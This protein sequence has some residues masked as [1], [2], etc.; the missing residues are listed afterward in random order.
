MKCYKREWF[1]KRHNLKRTKNDANEIITHDNYA[2][3]VLYDKRQ[4]C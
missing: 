1:R 2:E 4:L 3:I